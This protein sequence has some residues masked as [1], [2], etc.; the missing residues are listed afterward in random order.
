VV[1]GGGDD[2]E[3][4]NDAFLQ[5]DCDLAALFLIEQLEWLE[6]MKKY[7]DKM[8]PKSAELLEEALNRKK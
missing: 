1:G 7:Q 2:E 4:M 5:G 6:D 8:C 3:E